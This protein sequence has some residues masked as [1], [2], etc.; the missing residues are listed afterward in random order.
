LQSVMTAFIVSRPE[1]ESWLAEQAKAICD[2]VSDRQKTQRLGKLD[3]AIAKAM[4]ELLAA[5]KQAALEA[6]EAEFPSEAA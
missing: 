2:Q 3:D 6:V 5:R 1:F 4:A